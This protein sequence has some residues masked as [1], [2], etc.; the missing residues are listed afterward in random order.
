MEVTLGATSSLK[1]VK[2]FLTSL[3]RECPHLCSQNPAIEVYRM[4]VETRSHLHTL[5]LKVL[6]LCNYVRLG[7][8]IGL[9]RGGGRIPTKF[10]CSCFTPPLP[11]FVKA[12]IAQ[13]V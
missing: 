8:P 6:L 5:F 13:S 4:L 3:K 11:P 7:V 2:K 10:L 9:F 12:V 1:L